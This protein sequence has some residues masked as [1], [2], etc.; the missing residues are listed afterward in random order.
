MSRNADANAARSS[1]AS[2]PAVVSARA[3]SSARGAF[4]VACGG[5]ASLRPLTI[6]CNNPDDPDDPDSWCTRYT[7]AVF[8]GRSIV[9]DGKIVVTTYVSAS[10]TWSQVL[11]DFNTWNRVFHV[12]DADTGKVIPCDSTLVPVT[13]QRIMVFES[14]AAVVPITFTITDGDRT[15]TVQP[16]EA[17]VFPC[18][19]LYKEASALADGRQFVL[20]DIN[21]GAVLPSR[22]G[23]VVCNTAHYRVDFERIA[24]LQENKQKRAGN[25]AVRRA[26]MMANAAG[27]LVNAGIGGK[28]AV[29][30]AVKG[31][32]PTWFTGS[33]AAFT[34]TT[35]TV[36]YDADGVQETRDLD[37]LAVR[38]AAPVTEAR[39]RKYGT[40][41]STSTVRNDTD[42]GV[43][44]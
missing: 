6:Y 42:G 12:V 34:N 21:S 2:L 35:L 37:G 26:K 18:T 23:R 10:T 44:M 24:R 19:T 11:R 22:A 16:H 9:W 32:P 40:G 4:A 15:L 36:T 25:A 17:L 20:V 31:G 28:I 5:V 13:V 39:K 14:P 7:N 33:V 41:T 43:D 38:A 27:V 1:G 30:W 8:S 29:Q 3:P